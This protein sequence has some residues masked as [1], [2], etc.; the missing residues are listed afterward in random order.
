MV[1]QEQVDGLGNFHVPPP[2]FDGISSVLMYRPYHKF[3]SGNPISFWPGKLP[4]P[5][6]DYEDAKSIPL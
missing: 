4:S 1:I 6:G 3:L 2:V 5:L